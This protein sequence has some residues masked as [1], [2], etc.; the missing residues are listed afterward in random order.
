METMGHFAFLE[1]EAKISL[2]YGPLVSILLFKRAS[3]PTIYL[4]A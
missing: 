3:L 2:L 1:E 4:A